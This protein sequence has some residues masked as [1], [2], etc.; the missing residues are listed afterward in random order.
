MRFEA[1]Q[2]WFFCSNIGHRCM[3]RLLPDRGDRR[4]KRNGLADFVD[5]L[6]DHPD[7]GA[8]SSWHMRSAGK[9][10]FEPSG[11][12]RL[13][14]LLQAG[15]WGTLCLV[16][17]AA[18]HSKGEILMQFV[19]F[20]IMFGFVVTTFLLRPMLRLLRKRH[21]PLPLMVLPALLILAALLGSADAYCSYWTFSWMMRAQIG[22]GPN[23]LFIDLGYIL[24]SVIYVLWITLY[25]SLNYFI[26]TIDDRLRL[27]RLESATRESEL[28]LLRAQ[29]N[30]HFLFNALNTILAV[31]ADPPRVTQITHALADY[32]RFSLKQG[33]ALHPLGEELDALE[34]Y[35]QVEK[36]RFEEQL[37]YTLAAD[38]LARSHVVPG[39]LVQPLLENALKYG[40]RS[41]TSPL[42][43]S[44]AAT[45]R[46]DGSLILV[47]TNSG[48]WLPQTNATSTG[49]GII[50][51]RG[52]LQLLYGEHATLTIATESDQVSVRVELPAAAM[53]ATTAAAKSAASNIFTPQVKGMATT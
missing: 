44:I 20:R 8:Y 29:V 51:L 39:S 33:S 19:L 43:V 3:T 15:G 12:K 47:V 30:P 6:L 48:T 40:W 18:L 17:L 2:Q 14:W 13:F 36:I 22:D 37:E 27:A 35:L 7:S 1:T 23:Q 26:D 16:V 24:R 21:S 11:K 52:R 53:G 28:R 49:L 25:F 41:N 5:Y 31:A 50:N 9:C 46:A 42:R 34:N 38:D 10:L 45:S 4:A 32:L